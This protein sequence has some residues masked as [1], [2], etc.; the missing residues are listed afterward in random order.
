MYL[1][2]L[3][4]HMASQN[5]AMGLWVG[6]QCVIVAFSGHT[7][8]FFVV[9]YLMKTRKDNSGMNAMYII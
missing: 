9:R 4:S 3:K 6:L 1:N 5:D 8:L 2:K 7:H